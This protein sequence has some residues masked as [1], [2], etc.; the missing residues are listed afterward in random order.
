MTG[1]QYKTVSL[2]QGQGPVAKQYLETGAV[3]GH[4]VLLQNCHLL[5][6]WMPFLEG[7]LEQLTKAHAKFRLWL[8]TDPT[9]AFPMGILQRA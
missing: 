6:S 8:T 9:D 4:W 7:F 1:S 5:L 3:R 2:G